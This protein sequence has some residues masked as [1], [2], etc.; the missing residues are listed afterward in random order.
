MIRTA[1]PPLPSGGIGLQLVETLVHDD[2]K[3]R[4]DLAASP[5]GTRAVI[6]FPSVTGAGA[7]S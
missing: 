2:L 3:G 7:T 6:R 4:F 1:P 5:A